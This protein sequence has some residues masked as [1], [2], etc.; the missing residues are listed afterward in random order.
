MN[1]FTR[2]FRS[3]CDRIPGP[4][5]SPDVFRAPR[6]HQIHAHN[7]SNCATVLRTR[8]AHAESAVSQ[9]N[10]SKAPCT[11]KIVTNAISVW[12]KSPT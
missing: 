2:G 5:F 10:H 1:T 11:K 6:T 7:P 8:S 9:P 4:Q 12:P 3:R